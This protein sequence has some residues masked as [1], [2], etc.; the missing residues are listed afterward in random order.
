MTNNHQG[1]LER[2]L[3]IIRQHSRISLEIFLRHEAIAFPANEQSR[4]SDPMQTPFKFRVVHPWLPSQER[5]R[6]TRAKHG[7]E[8]VFRHFRGIGLHPL[9]IVKDEFGN[10]RFRH[11]ENVRNIES[12]GRTDFDAYRSG[13]DDAAKT[14][15]RF[16]R[17]V[18]GDP[19][20]N[21]AADQ[22]NPVEL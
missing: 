19:A 13:E 5:Q 4:S 12:V 9:G 3:E 11:G 20:A 18:G 6:F 17:H 16:G 2:G 22:I 21:R 8:L 14:L 7:G 1:K 15:G 10:I